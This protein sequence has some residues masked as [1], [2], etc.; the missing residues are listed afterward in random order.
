MDTPN[1]F[2]DLF[3]QSRKAFWNYP[4]RLFFAKDSW[5]N[6]FITFYKESIPLSHIISSIAIML[7]LFTQVNGAMMQFLSI[8]DD[9]LIEG[10]VTG[11]TETGEVQPLTRINPLISTNIQLEKDLSELIYE[12]LIKVDSK[13][14]PIPVL[15]DFFIIEKGKRYQFKLKPDLYWSD[16]TKI[17]A[18]DVFK[19]FTLIQ[20]LESNPQFSNLYS[21][22]ANK[23]EVVKSAVDPDAFEFRV[24]GDNVIP[25]FFEAISFKILPAHLIDDLSAQNIGM[26]DPYINRNPVGSGPYQ[27]SQATSQFIELKINPNYHGIKPEINKIKFKLFPNEAAALKALQNGQIHSLAG[28]NIESTLA[29]QKSNNISLYA[30]GPLYNQFWALYLNQTEGSNPLLKE[31]KIRQALAATVNKQ[32]LI[33]AQLGYAETANGPIPKTSFAYTPN[34]KYPYD[35]TKANSILDELGYI[36]G[37]DGFR[38]KDN[39]KLTFTMTYV[40]SAD[41]NILAEVLKKQFEAVGIE[42]VLDKATL[43]VAV[44][45]HIIP[46]NFEILFYGVQTLIDPDRYELFHSSQIRHPG[47]N[48]ASYVSEAKRTQVI[49]G[50]TERVPSVDDD[51]DDG[52]RLIDEKAR[53]KKYEDFQDVLASEVPVIFLFHPEDLYAVNNR[54]QG[55]DLSKVYFLEQRFNT[56]EDWTISPQFQTDTT[57]P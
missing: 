8:E 17:T 39:V 10:V 49:D 20:D 53:K 56:I 57:A 33:E 44:E 5:L 19:T 54:V 34:D 50:K 31:A 27:L 26:P 41:R 15:A 21:K 37:T 55:V 45:E 2:L 30:T 16:G 11:S 35:V 48:I 3:Y 25:G 52:R 6:S 38:Y 28:I 43:Q 32:E 13:G 23:L 1:R 24:T 29:L 18:E 22:A 7:L 4:E 40:D 9:M 36:K 12:S 51:L 46:R 14:D 42:L 47:L